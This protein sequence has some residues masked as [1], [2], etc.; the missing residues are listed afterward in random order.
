MLNFAVPVMPAGLSLWILSLSNRYF[1]FTYS[2][3]TE[4]GIYS[5]GAKFVS[6]V[7]LAVGAFALAWP[8]AAFSILDQDN[9]DRIYARTMTYFIFVSCSIVLVLSLFSSELVTLMTTKEFFPGARV[10]PILALG[11]VF[12][13]CYTIFA[14]GMN[15]TKKMRMIFPVTAV[16]AGFSLILNYFLIPPYGMMGAAWATL[17]SYMLMAFLSWWASERVYHMDYEWKNLGKIFGVMI[18]VFAISKVAMFDQLYYSVPI[19]LS[20][21]AAFFFALKYLLKLPIKEG[22]GSLQQ[23]LA[24]LI[25][26]L[27]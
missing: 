18:V 10:I 21:L 11:S 9:K 17:I 14:I 25:P 4:L 13:G 16:P 15:I 12:S 2:T 20:L 26:R 3:T 6:V 8:Q 23:T 1:L 27:H 19:K 24:G 5:V 7:S 22:W